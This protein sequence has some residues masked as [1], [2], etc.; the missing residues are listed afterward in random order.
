MLEREEHRTAPADAAAVDSNEDRNY[1]IADLANAFGV[2]TRALRFYE[3]EGLIAPRRQGTARI[4]SKRDRARLAW[5]LRAKRVG[6]SL[7]EVRDVLDLYDLGD[8]RV[9][10]RRVAL[11]KCRQRIGLLERQRVEIDTTI[12]ELTQFVDTIDKLE[13]PCKR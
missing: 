13:L 7:A 8:G 12:A 5:I 4:Y 9:E 10:Q 6:F 2:T 11:T 1:T 3:E